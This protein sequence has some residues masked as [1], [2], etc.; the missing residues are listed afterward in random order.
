MNEID[1]MI[2]YDETICIVLFV[3]DVGCG[4]QCGRVSEH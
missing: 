3:G 2:I 4:V 1:K